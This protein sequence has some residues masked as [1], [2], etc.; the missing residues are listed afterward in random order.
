MANV[1]NISEAAS[2][3]MHSMAFLAAQKSADPVSTREMASILNVS[4]NHLSKVVQRLVKA[5]LA[6]SV[7]GP[8]GGVTLAGEPED[9][10]LLDI[11]E[12]IEGKLETTKCLLKKKICAPGNCIL[13]D[14]LTSVDDKVRDNLS[15]TAL[16]QI[17]YVFAD[18]QAAEKA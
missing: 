11:F 12:A 9:I 13:G 18:F 14:L 15:N 5:G 6:E 8:R 17:S 7:R 3:A 10:T 4:D 2:L 16:S 1:I